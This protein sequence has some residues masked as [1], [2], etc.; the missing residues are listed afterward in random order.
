MALRSPPVASFLVWTHR[1]PAS[2]S[3]AHPYY[4]STIHATSTL[5]LRCW[6]PATKTHN[7]R[8]RVAEAAR[9][10]PLVFGRMWL[11][12]RVSEG[13]AEINAQVKWTSNGDLASAVAM[14]PPDGVFDGASLSRRRFRC[15]FLPW[16]PSALWRA[17]SQ[18]RESSLS[19]VPG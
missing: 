4:R 2:S 16:Y 19:R 13:Q 3:L 6:A 1:R 17:R 8:R 14:P 10:D 9:A 5:L 7:W 18:P 15:V 12:T 11:I